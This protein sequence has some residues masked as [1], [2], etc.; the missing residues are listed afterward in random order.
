M[1]GSAQDPEGSRPMIHGN[2][3][4]VHLKFD[5]MW[6]WM[7]QD[8]FGAKFTD[9]NNGFDD[10][11][12]DMFDTATENFQNQLFSLFSHVKTSIRTLETMEH[13]Y[14]AGKNK[15]AEGLRVTGKLLGITGAVLGVRIDVCIEPCTN[16]C[17]ACKPVGIQF[18]WGTGSR[19]VD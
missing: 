1:F 13:K 2:R 7:I 16:T 19:C 6:H 4:V 14:S 17:C 5:R 9:I 10:P 15:W 11:H 18:W 12:V 8:V 3:A